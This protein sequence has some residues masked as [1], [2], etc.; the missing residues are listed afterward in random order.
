M[1]KKSGKDLLTAV[2]AGYEVYQRVALAGNSNI[3]SYNIF[4]CLAVLMKL[5]DLPE[6][7][8]SGLWHRHSLCH[9]SHLSP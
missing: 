5:M 4:G 2:V 8:E 6:E 1:L 3:V 7:K 9:H